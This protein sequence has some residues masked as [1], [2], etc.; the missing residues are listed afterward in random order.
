MCRIS[1]FIVDSVGL[2]VGKVPI[3]IG[4]ACVPQIEIVSGE[5]T[6]IS[7]HGRV[8]QSDSDGYFSFDLY[9]NAEYTLLI[10][11][12]INEA[13]VVLVPDQA[14]VN[15]ADL[16]FPFVSL[17]EWYDDGIQIVPATA[18]TLAVA[19]DATKVIDYSVIFRNGNEAYDDEAVFKSADEDVFTISGSSSAGAL[20]ITGVGAGTALVKITRA[21]GSPGVMVTTAPDII[22]ELSVTVA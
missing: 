14:A 21:K 17:V 1:G 16:I 22:G 8:V 13:R 12:W 5:S 18:P 9:R 7:P 11:G 19:I 10:P 2:K 20:T 4:E 15:L 6:L 3:H